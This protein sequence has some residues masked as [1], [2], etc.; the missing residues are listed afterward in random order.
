[1]MKKVMLTAALVALAVIA[2]TGAVLAATTPEGGE[3]SLTA[4]RAEHMAAIY[5]K[6]TE[7]QRAA[8]EA[9]RAEFEAAKA[10]PVQEKV[11]SEGRRV[12]K[13]DRGLH[14]MVARKNADGT[15]STACIRSA[16]EFAAFLAGEEASHRHE[17]VSQ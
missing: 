17:G 2:S 14:V 7:E 10:Q 9:F 12:V 16:D 4:A 3:P 11:S 1:M 6:L 5:A 13:M 8:V 15:T